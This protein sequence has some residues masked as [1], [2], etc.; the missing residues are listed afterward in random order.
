M[1]KPFRKEFF[2]RF[3]VIPSPKVVTRYLDEILNSAGDP[4]LAEL[5]R[6]DKEKVVA[7]LRLLA[8]YQVLRWMALVAVLAPGLLVSKAV[9]N[10]DPGWL[11]YVVWTICLGGVFYF[12]YMYQVGPWAVRLL[13]AGSPVVRWLLNIGPITWLLGGYALW[14]VVAHALA[15]SPQ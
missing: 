6:Q 11:E 3:C 15:N 2:Y 8:W 14:A 13:P 5:G 12:L 1:A 10:F 7:L 9:F 4:S